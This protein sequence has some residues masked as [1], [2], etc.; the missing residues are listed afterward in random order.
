RLLRF[1]SVAG[2]AING[3]P[4]D[5]RTFGLLLSCLSLIMDPVKWRNEQLTKNT[6]LVYREL[7]RSLIYKQHFF[8]LIRRLLIH[9]CFPAAPSAPSTSPSSSSSSSP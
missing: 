2:G 6:L 1:A 5:I 7:V 4:K 9:L 3:I 8:T